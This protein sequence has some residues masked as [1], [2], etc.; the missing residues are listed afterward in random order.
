MRVV[1]LISPPQKSKSFAFSPVKMDSRKSVKY[2]F[3][4]GI[5]YDLHAEREKISENLV[6]RW[7]V[8]Y[9]LPGRIK[10]ELHAERE[11][12]S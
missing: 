3:P 7:L 11:V 1:F 12:E 2:D 6:D 4:G 9:D 5:K 10:Y 8:R